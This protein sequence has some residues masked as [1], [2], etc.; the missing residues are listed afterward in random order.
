MAYNSEQNTDKKDVM[1][2]LETENYHSVDWR[3][4][5]NEL[6]TEKEDIIQVYGKRLYNKLVRYSQGKKKLINIFR[7]FYER[8]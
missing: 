6:Q 3:H 5:K 8:K 1:V 4:Y 7:G 2:I